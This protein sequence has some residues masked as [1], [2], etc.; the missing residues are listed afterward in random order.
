MGNSIYKIDP[1]ADLEK[2]ILKTFKNSLLVQNKL[3]ELPQKVNEPYEEVLTTDPL[4]EESIVN[5]HEIIHER[6][7]N[8]SK[9]I[10]QVKIN[11]AELFTHLK[12]TY[13]ETSFKISGQSKKSEI[14]FEVA[15]EQL[16]GPN[17]QE[18]LKYKNALSIEDANL[19]SFID[20]AIDEALSITETKLPITSD[21]TQ[22]LVNGE[23][24]SQLLS[25]LISQL[26][27]NKEYQK[28]PF[29][30]EGDSITAPGKRPIGETLTLSL[31]PSIPIM[32]LTTAFT[33]EGMKPIK[34][35]V[36]EKNKVI[37]QLVHH[38]MG[39]YLNRTPNYITGNIVVK[40]GSN[41]KEILISKC[42]ECLEIISFASLLIDD[43]T[44]TWSSEIKLARLHRK[45]EAT[46]MIKGGVVS[47]DL[48]ENFVNFQFD[49]EIVKINKTS[50]GFGVPVGYIGP[51]HMLINTGIKIVGA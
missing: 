49:K 6:L 15:I 32:G 8:K 10:S 40:E 19:E 34:A 46:S 36:I 7:N 35:Q 16:P 29:L 23:T 20:D 25:S 27:A 21:T 42:H 3:W 11:S 9:D 50:G 17:T 43:N 2:Q 51:K 24:I 47:G 45:G 41:T 31:D 1:L 22:I 26:D 38:K 44:L 37:H 28:L 5:A 33:D 18:V 30:T 39:Q 48:K 12:T 14:Y 4:I 13:T